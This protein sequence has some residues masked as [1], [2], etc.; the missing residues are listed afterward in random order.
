MDAQLSEATWRTARRSADNG[1]ACIEVAA[2]W[3]TARRSADN[4]GNCVEVAVIDAAE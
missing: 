1:G 2:T 4:G 3:R